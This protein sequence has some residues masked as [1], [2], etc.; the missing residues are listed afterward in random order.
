MSQNEFSLIE[1]YFSNPASRHP[2]ENTILGIG[3]DAAV[4]QAPVHHQ[5]VATIDTL[6]AGRHFPPQ[7][8]ARNIA[9]KSL[10]VN[11]SDLVAMAATPAFFLLSL[12][13]PDVNDDFLTA[14]SSG[15]FEAAEAFGI[16]LVG[17]DTCKGPLSIT[18]Q[19]SGFV[20]SDRF[21]TRST[22]SVGD[23]IFVSGKLGAAALGLAYVQGR[24]EL[25]AQQS[26]TCIDALNRPLPRLDLIPLL[27]DFATSAIDLSDG[28][29]GDLAHILAQSGVGAR[30]DKDKLPVID[31]ILQHDQYHYALSG[32][33][34]YQILFTVAEQN[35]DEV[36]NL[37][38]R[39]N[40]DVTDIGVITKTGLEWLDATNT[41]DLSSYRGFDH[42]L[43]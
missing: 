40:S 2:G 9:Y 39:S 5:L 14:F 34:D 43:P 19:A 10:A 25:D 32:G 28:L 24:V 41:I 16:Q 29:V 6:V 11:V 4:L 35:R 3:D 23:R 12:T 7:T 20:P 31:W 37:A 30:L 26:R 21:V 38:Q 17:G 8:S 33:D 36:M 15:L 27:R 18:I 22:A 1:Q 13:L 42:F